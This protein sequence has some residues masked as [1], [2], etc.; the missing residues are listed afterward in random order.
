MLENNPDLSVGHKWK[1]ESLR[2]DI[3]AG[4]ELYPFWAAELLHKLPMFW[5]SEIKCPFKTM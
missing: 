1:M 2:F 4:V 5:L 3:C